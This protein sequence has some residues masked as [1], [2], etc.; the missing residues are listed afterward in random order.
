MRSS[1]TEGQSNFVNPGIFIYN[2]SQRC[3]DYA[4]AARVVNLNL[5]R[6]DH[7]AVLEDVLFQNPIH[8]GVGADS[9]IGLVYRPL[10]SDNIIFTGVV[11]A[12]VPFQGFTDIYTGKTLYSVAVNVRFRF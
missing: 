7:T 12:F 2:G 5:I 6:F 4:Q 10:L 8:A 9:G 3:E 1:K 11:N